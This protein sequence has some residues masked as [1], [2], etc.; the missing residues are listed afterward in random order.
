[1][2]YL[3]ADSNKQSDPKTSSGEGYAMGFLLPKQ[4]S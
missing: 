2:M 4:T 1:M 3:T